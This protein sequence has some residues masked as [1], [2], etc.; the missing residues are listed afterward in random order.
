MPDDANAPDL[1]D[2]IWRH[3]GEAEWRRRALAEVY[4]RVCRL[5]PERS[6]VL[7][8][9]G[10]V[11]VLARRLRDERGCDCVVVDQS[12]EAAR[13][14]ADA[15]VA[16]ICMPFEDAL[17]VMAEWLP[18]VVVATEFME[19]LDS[20]LRAALL[21]CGKNVGSA[22]VSV[23][24]NRLGPDEEPQHKVKYTAAELLFQLRSHFGADC[25]VEVLGPYLLGVCGKIAHK[26]FTLSVCFPARDEAADI[27]ATL[28]SFRG[29]ADQLIVGIDPRSSDE[30]EEIAAQYADFT[31]KLDSPEGPESD[32]AP[33]GGVHFAHIRNQ[34][35]N[36][37]KGDWIFMTEAH[38][39]LVAGD[40][41][42]LA[43]D[44]AMPRG[45]KLGYVV[46]T[47]NGQA[48]AFPWLTRNEQNI[49][50]SRMTHNVVDYP[51]GALH[52][53]LPTVRT[54][55][56]RH[57]D[58]ELA[59]QAQRTVQNRKTLLEDWLVRESPASL[60]YLGAEWRE[61]DERR[62]IER[63]EQFLA[64]PAKNGPMRYHTRLMLAKCYA[65]AGQKNDARSVLLA[66][67]GDDWTRVEHWL[68]L[69]DLAFEAG[70]FEEAL[71]FYRYSATAIN[72]PPFALWWID[73]ATYTYLPAQRLAMTYG[74]LG[75]G[76]E[77]LHWARRVRELLPTNAP[78]EAFDE[79]DSN[80]RILEE[81]LAAA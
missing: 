21:E 43:L 9:G 54:L 32:R 72:E 40:D 4:A 47:G 35:M 77:A 52:V 73:L 22:L 50:Y 7:D 67:V 61:H 24:N 14:A 1:W 2:R 18:D 78:A 53:R 11:G 48:W 65:R 41:V 38:E 15:G 44:R 76:D 6:K 33:E 19:H 62:A 31:F 60:H 5:V 3:D 8:V 58:R 81:A 30:T 66:A 71:Q 26:G 75:R 13:R 63:F 64:L 23:P 16:S 46:R 27:E 55:H 74:E 51:E 80:I 20:P 56:E 59:R 57:R 69:G 17:G 70:D 45:A 34:C 49:R 79:V 42:L 68:W 39:R 29:V 36:L 28:A 12:P 37:C 10:G 25:R